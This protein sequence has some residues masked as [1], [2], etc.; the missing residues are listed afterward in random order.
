M[1]TECG[2]V[3][4]RASALEEEVLIVEYDIQMRS[5]FVP[6]HILLGVKRDSSHFK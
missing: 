2:G 5:L 6:G 4:V 1:S 3:N